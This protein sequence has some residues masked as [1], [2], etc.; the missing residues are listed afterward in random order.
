MST[1][2]TSHNSDVSI[3]ATSVQNFIGL[4]TILVDKTRTT[5]FADTEWATGD[6]VDYYAPINP[7]GDGYQ[8]PSGS[9]AGSGAGLAVYPWLD[10][11]TG[12]DSCG[13]ILSPAAV[14]ILF[15]MWPSLRVT[16]VEGVL[17]WSPMFDTFG[18]F[19]RDLES[20]VTA[21]RVIHADSEAKKCLS[22]P[23][24]ILYPTDYLPVEHSE[25]QDFYNNFIAKLESLGI[26]KEEL[27]LSVL[28]LK[29]NPIQTT[30][31][32]SEY[33]HNNLPYVY[34]LAQFKSYEKFA[35]EY[36]EAYGVKPI[37]N[38]QGQFRFEWAPTAT[39]SMQVEGLKQSAVFKKWIEAEILPVNEY[40]CSENLLLLPWTFAS[41]TYRNLYHERPAWVGAGFFFYD[42]LPYAQAPET[43]L[44]IGQT[45][46]HSR[47]TD[48]EEWLPVSNGIIASQNNDIFRTEAVL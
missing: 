6:W 29:S 27:D 2:Q 30:Q 9:S 23:R 34:E 36:K 33:L 5:Q 45:R 44:P 13:S 18:V 39:E 37:F 20:Y 14:Q 21:A 8:S 28:W 43:I 41:P 31:A 32:L 15:N 7:R 22:K 3:T 24:R 26:Q 12:T 42:I 10:F 47:V 16:D 25:S 38:P 11:A 17:P 48:S 35:R 4:G 1:T 19:P 40:G 46:N